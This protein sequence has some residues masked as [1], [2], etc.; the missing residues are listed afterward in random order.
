M[1]LKPGELTTAVEAREQ[2]FN[3][4]SVEL[5]LVVL[6]AP[7]VRRVGGFNRTSVELKLGLSVAFVAAAGAVL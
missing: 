2:G 6:F 5:K 1:E 7:Q 4:T 3:R